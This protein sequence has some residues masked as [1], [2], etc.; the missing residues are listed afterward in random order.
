MKPSTASSA[1]KFDKTLRKPGGFLLYTPCIHSF[2]FL[3]TFVTIPKNLCVEFKK[4][5][6]NKFVISNITADSTSIQ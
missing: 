1:I 5:G 6:I 4:E 3:Q 2:N